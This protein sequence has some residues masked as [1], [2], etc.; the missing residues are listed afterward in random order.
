MSFVHLHCHSQYSLLDG[1]SNIKKLVKRAKE[2]EMP[3]VA[4]T[5]HGTMHGT[6]EFFH[7]AVD[8]G[9]KPIIGLEAY[10]AP[11]RMQDRDSKVDLKPF[12]LLLLAEN[13]TGYKNLLKIASAAQ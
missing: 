13:Q 7:A 4:L 10:L 5:D 8:A 6:I 12:H 9:V 1:F 11:R 2:M 3:A